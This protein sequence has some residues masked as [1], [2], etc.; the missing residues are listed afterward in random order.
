MREL[1]GACLCPEVRRACIR[2]NGRRRVDRL[3]DGGNRITVHKS[4]RRVG[5]AHVDTARAVHIVCRFVGVAVDAALVAA[6]DIEVALRDIE[7]AVHIVNV[8]IRC[9]A[10]A[11]SCIGNLRLES[12][13]AGVRRNEGV[14]RFI[15]VGDRVAVHESR[16]RGRGIGAELRCAA[17]VDGGRVLRAVDARLASRTKR[18]VARRDGEAAVLVGDVVVIGIARAEDGICNLRL[19]AG[20]SC[21]RR[22]GRTR[23]NRLRDCRDRIAVDEVRAR[24]DAEEI[25][26]V[27]IVC[28]AVR[29]AVDAALVACDERQRSL[30]DVEVSVDVGD[31][32]VRRRA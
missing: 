25:R 15:D 21:I 24:L 1:C 29:R 22:D 10:R 12:R 11:E 9:L 17:R 4:R 3:R 18:Q 20:R 32:I 19:E 6:L 28:G 26:A 23:I 31:V 27:H 30:R 2:R 13:R 8:V 16:R 14:R 7:A 5:R